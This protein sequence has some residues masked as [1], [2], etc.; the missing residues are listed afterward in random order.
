[1]SVDGFVV[2][3]AEILNGDEHCAVVSVDELIFGFLFCF[4]VFRS[5]IQLTLWNWAHW[6]VSGVAIPPP[7]K[8]WVH[9]LGRKG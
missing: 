3:L 7:T 9:F 5:M 1:M 8:I 4:W 2:Q 6:L